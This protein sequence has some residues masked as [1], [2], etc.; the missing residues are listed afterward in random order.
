MK[1]SSTLFALLLV[2][3]HSLWMGSHI[4]GKQLGDNTALD[5][6]KLF[7]YSPAH[8]QKFE[9]KTSLEKFLVNFKFAFFDILQ[10]I[11]NHDDLNLHNHFST[12]YLFILFCSL[13]I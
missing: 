13:L 9:P 5:N 11:S 12:S 4:S 3:I 1:S 2:L 10:L 6:V 8:Q 7:S